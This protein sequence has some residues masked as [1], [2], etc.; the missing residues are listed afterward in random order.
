MN[1]SG[2]SLG[3]VFYSQ[4]NPLHVFTTLL[5]ENVNFVHLTILSIALCGDGMEGQEDALP[6]WQ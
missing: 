3:A 2:F 4:I 6:N 1:F 5:Y